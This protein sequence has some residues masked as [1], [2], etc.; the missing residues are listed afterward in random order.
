VLV[1]QVGFSEWTTA[2]QLRHPRYLGLRRDKDPG[3]VTRERPE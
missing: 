1:C 3:S 2:G